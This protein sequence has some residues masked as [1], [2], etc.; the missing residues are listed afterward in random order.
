MKDISWHFRPIKNWGLSWSSE[1]VN[2][3]IE[4]GRP[5]PQCQSLEPHMNKWSKRNCLRPKGISPQ[6]APRPSYGRVAAFKVLKRNIEKLQVTEISDES[7]K[8]LFFGLLGLKWPVLWDLWCSI[9]HGP[10]PIGPFTG[11]WNW[12]NWKWRML[13]SITALG[14]Y[15]K[16]SNV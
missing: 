16:P 8:P 15:W 9:V 6:N 4:L 14:T 13:L 5:L 3:I 7:G 11:W 2:Y 10:S 1:N 12:L